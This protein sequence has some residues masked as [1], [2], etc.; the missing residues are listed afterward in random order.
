MTILVDADTNSLVKSTVI[1]LD[2]M[3][4]SLHLLW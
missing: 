3:S 4:R 1:A 2:Q